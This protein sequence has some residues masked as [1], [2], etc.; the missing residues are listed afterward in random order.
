MINYSIIIPHRNIPHLLQRCLDSIPRRDDIQIIIVD[1]NSDVS[2]VNFD[3]FPGMGEKGVDIIFTKEGK[4]AGYA[5]NVGLKYAKGKWLLF[6]DADDYFTDEILTICDDNCLSTNI[7]ELIV[8]NSKSVD[9]KTLKEIKKK[10]KQT[11]IYIK[12]QD[13][14]ILRYVSHLVWGK[15]YLL[16]SIRKYKIQFDEVPAANDVTFAG[17]AG[18]YL[19]NL[20]FD[21]RIGYVFTARE[22][23]ISTN[24]SSSYLNSHIKV[25]FRYNS[26]LKEKKINIK[27][28]INILGLLRRLYMVDKQSFKIQFHKYY[29][30][31]SFRRKLI[32]LYQCLTNF[33]HN[34]FS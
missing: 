23:S 2:I 28:W 30:Q 3:Q 5:R 8:F 13:E 34:S 24:Y 17:Y 16:D 1:D 33:L 22:S 12:N 21:S 32:D 19:K 10:E 25:A 29:T 11:S 9:S 6:A 14:N 20:R 27:Y 18:F 7:N 26:F 15:I 31:I 4:G